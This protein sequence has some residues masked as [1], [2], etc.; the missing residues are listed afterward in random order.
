MNKIITIAIQARSTSTRLP[1]KINKEIGGV[2][3]LSRIISSA[4]NAEIYL[5]RYTERNN[6]YVNV[7]VLCPTGDQE[8]LKYK[9]AVSIF[10]GDEEDVL[11]RYYDMAEH[12][13]SDYVVR[14]TADCPLIPSF[15]ISSIIMKASQ[16]GYDYMSNVDPDCRT[17]PDGWDCECISKQLLG[18]THSMAKEKY[19]REHV[20]PHMRKFKKGWKH[21]IVV[22]HLDLSHLKF[23][24]DTK[25]EYDRVN[26]EY[27]KLTDKLTKANY[28]YGKANVHRL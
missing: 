26:Q 10:E 14:I 17:S 5:N 27:E 18:Y 11:K 1:N 3:I 15:V 7:V 25:E 20:T 28:L 23:S 12:Y 24:V 4:K 16:G 6:H 2:S 21:G 19:D 13:K 22:S 8:V 9:S